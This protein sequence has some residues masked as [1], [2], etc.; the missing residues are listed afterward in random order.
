MPQ[1]AIDAGQFG[2]FVAAGRHRR[3]QTGASGSTRHGRT[4][5]GVS[6]QLSGLRGALPV[7]PVFQTSVTTPVVATRTALAAAMRWRPG[8]GTSSSRWI[9]AV[10]WASR[11]AVARLQAGRKW[12]ACGPCGA[13]YCGATRSLKR[14]FEHVQRQRLATVRRDRVALERRRTVD[15]GCSNPTRSGRPPAASALGP[16]GH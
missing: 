11:A 14:L 1:R 10:S 6:T 8:P 3:G 5:R 13:D 9:A 2:R 15:A 12:T 7:R 16:P 4:G